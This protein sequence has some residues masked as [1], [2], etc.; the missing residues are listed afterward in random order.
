MQNYAQRH[1]LRQAEA[2]E[3][4]VGRVYYTVFLFRPLWLCETIRESTL[5]DWNGLGHVAKA[6]VMSL[7]GLSCYRSF[8]YS[9]HRRSVSNLFRRRPLRCQWQWLMEVGGQTNGRSSARDIQTGESSPSWW[10]P[11][12]FADKQIYKSSSAIDNLAGSVTR[13]RRVI[14]CILNIATHTQDSIMYFLGD[15]FNWTFLLC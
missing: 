5:P 12:W 1:D 10:Y 9:M 13:G 7:P 15:F 14:E 4:A 3:E 11:Q 8:P 6:G 2:W